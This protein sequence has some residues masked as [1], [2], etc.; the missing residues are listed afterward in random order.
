MYVNYGKKN[1]YPDYLNYLVEN[2]PI[3]NAIIKSMQDYIIGEGIM[4]S[5]EI[6]IKLKGNTTPQ[7]YKIIKR[8]IYDKIVTGAFAV[9]LTYNKLGEIAEIEWLDIRNVRL[10]YEKTVAYYSETFGKGRRGDLETYST[11]DNFVFGKD[12]NNEYACVFYDDN[13]SRGIYAQP[14]YV[15]SLRAIETSIEIEKFHH[16]SIQQNL[17]ASAII[18]IPDAGN[19]SEEEKQAVEE[20]FRENFCG[21]ENGS[22]FIL[23]F[24][25]DKEHSVVVEKLADEQFDKKYEALA[26]NTR[27]NIFAGFRMQSCLCGYLADNIGFNTQE[28]SE[29]F[30]IYNKTVILPLQNQLVNTFNLIFNTRDSLV[31]KPFNIS[32]E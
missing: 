11:F 12:E 18:S 19:Y 3:M 21:S 23:S 16:A 13:D 4:F 7:L 28:Y 10:N 25:E 29:A 30:K 17:S 32:F 27:K 5:D 8:V 6:R 24:C 2:S 31:I 20:K 1:D 26:D 15:G 22:S 9:K 14:S